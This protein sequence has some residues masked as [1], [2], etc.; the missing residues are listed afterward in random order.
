MRG[1]WNNKNK[2]K[3]RLWMMSKKWYKNRDR[4]VKEFSN[5]KLK[6]WRKWMN[7][8]NKSSK[9]RINHRSKD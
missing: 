5:S 3:A 8:K 6:E 7:G 1:N 9:Q 4:K 2:P